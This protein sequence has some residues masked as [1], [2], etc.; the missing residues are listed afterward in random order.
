MSWEQITEGLNPSDHEALL[1]RLVDH[2]RAQPSEAAAHHA[3]G[4][5]LLTLQQ[6]LDAKACWQRCLALDPAH[7]DARL[8]LAQLL[9]RIGEPNAALALDAASAT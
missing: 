3:L 4:A 7:Q 8:Q 5:V 9:I 2:C 1:G 6:P